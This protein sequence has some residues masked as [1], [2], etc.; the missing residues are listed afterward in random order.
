MQTAVMPDRAHA[1]VGELRD[2]EFS[3]DFLTIF[4]NTASMNPLRKG[5]RRMALANRC[6]VRGSISL[7]KVMIRQQQDAT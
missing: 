4:H 5:L 3:A 7:D 1:V 6:K 2:S